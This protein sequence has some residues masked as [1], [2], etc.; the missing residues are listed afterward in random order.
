MHLREN[1]KT[2]IYKTGW[3]ILFCGHPVLIIHFD[4]DLNTLIIDKTET[5][6]RKDDIDTPKA[7][8]RCSEEIISMI[9]HLKVR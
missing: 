1:V 4:L 6:S 9:S 2:Q 5:D 3:K 7:W 8:V